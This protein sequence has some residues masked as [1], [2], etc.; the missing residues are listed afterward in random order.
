MFDCR[1]QEYHPT[2]PGKNIQKDVE[3]LS[4]PLENDLYT[5]SGCSISIA[6]L[7]EGNWLVTPL[8]CHYP[9]HDWVITTVRSSS[10][11]LWGD[12]HGRCLTLSDQHRHSLFFVIVMNITIVILVITLLILII[13]MILISIILV[14]PIILIIRMIYI[15]I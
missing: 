13:R 3:N 11:D 15:Y 1:Q 12:L 14:I 9:I 4:I 2:Y 7:L 6:G 8:I 5:N 10:C